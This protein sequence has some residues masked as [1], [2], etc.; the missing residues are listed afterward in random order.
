MSK[1]WGGFL[2]EKT[3]QGFSKPWGTGTGTK[4]V[5]EECWG[6]ERWGRNVRDTQ[7]EET[8]PALQPCTSG[9]AGALVAL[10][11]LWLPPDGLWLPS[12]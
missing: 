10:T 12:Q 5:W 7:N 1:A 9:Q 8:V 11:L 2:Q 4:D 6:E 3:R